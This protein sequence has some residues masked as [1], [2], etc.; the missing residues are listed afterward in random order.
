[1]TVCLPCLC[2]RPCQ[3]SAMP[4]FL[5]SADRPTWVVE[6]KQDEKRE[7]EFFILELQSVAE[8]LAG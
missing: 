1:M 4:A 7:Y 8:S 6:E 3:I 5:S 2:P